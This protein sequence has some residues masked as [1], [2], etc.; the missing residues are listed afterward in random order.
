M[1]R[2]TDVT[3]E[4]DW[5]R[6]LSAAAFVQRIVPDAILVGGTAAALHADH[7][8]SADDDHV[9]VNLKDRFARVLC[10]LEGAAGWKTNRLTPPVQ[11]L[12]DFYGVDTGIRNLIRTAPLE[13]M[14]VDTN[15]GPITIPTMEEML[16][17]KAW[18][19]VSRNK[20]RDYI[21]TVALSDK[22]GPERTTSAMRTFDSL[23]P[24]PDVS[25]TQQLLKQLAEPHPTDPDRDLRIY[26]ALRQPWNDWRYI[27]ERAGKL[28]VQLFETQPRCERNS[29]QSRP[30][31]R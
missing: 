6:V 15:A 17:I 25:A 10:D 23:Y 4:D 11:I 24:Q 14:T 2:L 8:F 3:T 12:G 26:K 19:T 22:L 28:A 27:T 21:D 18:L 31:S 13:T 5:E 16:R 9:I 30:H 20:T 7:R 29:K 1:K